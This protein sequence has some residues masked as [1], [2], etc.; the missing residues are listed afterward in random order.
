[1]NIPTKLSAKLT[2]E[3]VKTIKELI[4]DGKSQADVARIFDVSQPNINRIVHGHTWQEVP[5]P[6]MSRGALDMDDFFR[7]LE[8]LGLRH[9]RGII[10]P[11]LANPKYHLAPPE[12]TEGEASKEP[13]EETPEEPPEEPPTELTPE[14]RE[15]RDKMAADIMTERGEQAE[16]D[17]ELQIAKGIKASA[18][19]ARKGKRKP[20]VKKIRGKKLPW[21]QIQKK[22][23]RN[24][25]VVLAIE[26]KHLREC[27]CIA[28]RALPETLWNTPKAEQVVKE[29]GVNLGTPIKGNFF[30][31]KE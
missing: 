21:A 31:I 10:N 15:A 5:W 3:E 6:N 9:R 29:V 23:P 20:P 24:P 7:R 17:M 22:A 12:I 11:G 19:T 30:K 4:W 16:E 18:K 28:F 1:M 25:M 2:F 14:E 27:I 26:D 8:A 13:P